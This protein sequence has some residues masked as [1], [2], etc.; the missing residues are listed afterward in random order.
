MKR[1][2]RYVMQARRQALLAL[3]VF[4]VSVA[5]CVWSVALVDPLPSGGMLAAAIGVTGLCYA[6]AML[7]EA[8][9]LLRLSGREARWEWQASIRPKL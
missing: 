5:G 3:M 6:A 1:S 2:E 9:R 7:R 8:V 4:S